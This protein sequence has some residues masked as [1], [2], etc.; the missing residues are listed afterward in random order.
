MTVTYIAIIIYSTY[1]NPAM[2]LC[3]DFFLLIDFLP[4][5]K[6]LL[7]PSQYPVEGVLV[8]RDEVSSRG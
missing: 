1:F 4:A 5:K 8:M 7:K 3:V 6:A 2:H